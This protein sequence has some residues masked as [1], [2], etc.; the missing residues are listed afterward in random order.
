MQSYSLDALLQRKDPAE[1]ASVDGARAFLEE[2]RECGESR[3]E[4]TG[5]G[6][7]YRFEG[8]RIVGSALV[9]EQTVIHAAF[10]RFEKEARDEP[11]AGYRQRR[12]FR[13]IRR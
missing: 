3:F 7:D 10:F 1:E 2:A 9:F 11:M 13:R 6:Y 5:E 8:A 12:G 4:S